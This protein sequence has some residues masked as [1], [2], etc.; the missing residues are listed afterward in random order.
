MFKRLFLIEFIISRLEALPRRA[1]T[2]VQG[3]MTR[4]NNGWA[5]ALN[6]PTF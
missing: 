6:W 2:Q 4:I 3:K 5:L 1:L